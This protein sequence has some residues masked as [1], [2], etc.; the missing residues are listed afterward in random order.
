MAK[1]SITDETLLD[2]CSNHECIYNE[3]CFCHLGS[4]MLDEEGKCVY[5]NTRKKGGTGYVTGT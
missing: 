3:K 4:I 5:I 1:E 2:R